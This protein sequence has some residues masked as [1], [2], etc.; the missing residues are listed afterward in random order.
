ME[1]MLLLGT[2]IVLAGAIGLLQAHGIQFWADR[3]GPYGI[4]WS[5]LLE[6]TGLGCG[7]G[8]RSGAACLG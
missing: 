1:R 2:V 8:G 5:A 7:G 6:A 3:L 4:A